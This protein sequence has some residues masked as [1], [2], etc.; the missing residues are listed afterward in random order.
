MNCKKTA[1]VLQIE[2][3]KLSSSE[4]R[5]FFDR[6]KTLYN[7][8]DQKYT[9]VADSYGF[10]CEGCKDNCCLTRFYHHTYLE[11]LYILEACNHLE[12][13]MPLKIKKRAQD[14][15]RKTAEADAKGEAVRLMCPLNFDE[16]CVLYE[17]RPIICRL[18]G[19]AHELN[20]PSRGIVRGSGCDVFEMQT[21]K[22]KYVKFDRTPFYIDMVN[23]E[24]ELKQTFGFGRKI[25]KTIAEMLAV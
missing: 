13:D 20:F 17:Y 4:C 19:I 18:H 11:Y 1:V 10:A 14:V 7:A 24:N 16:L 21:E 9:E 25:K 22:K 12:R 6:L 2:N 5:P 15:C 23:L 3:V 8:I